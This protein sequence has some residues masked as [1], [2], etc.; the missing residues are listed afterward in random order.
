MVRVEALVPGFLE[1]RI[2]ERPAWVADDQRDPRTAAEV[3]GKFALAFSTLYFALFAVGI[4]NPIILL[5]VPLVV[6][7]AVAWTWVLWHL[8]I[9]EDGVVPR[10]R[11]LTTGLAIGTCSW[12]TVGPLLIVGTTVPI[13]LQDGSVDVSGQLLEPLAFGMYAS[14]AGF[15]TTAGVPTIASV[16]LALWTLDYEER[17]GREKRESDYEFA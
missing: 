9:P 1:R 6:A 7:N 15:V 4:W 2:P 16:G 13:L 3:Y 14:A 10:R 5:F 12:L 17:N 11:A 8:R